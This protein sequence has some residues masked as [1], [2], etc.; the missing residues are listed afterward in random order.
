MK[1]EA[2]TRTLK[3]LTNVLKTLEQAVKT[4]MLKL[5]IHKVVKSPLQI[6][7][8]LKKLKEN[9]NQRKE[10]Q[11]IH[12]PTHWRTLYQILMLVQEQEEN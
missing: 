2:T 12:H 4:L 5:N 11:S 1:L 7:K 9:E 6:L 10:K 8:A 3:T